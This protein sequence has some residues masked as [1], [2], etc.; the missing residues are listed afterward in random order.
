MTKIVN[1]PS[2]FAREALVGFCDIHAFAGLTGAD[3][4]DGALMGN[5]KV[6]SDFETC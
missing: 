3:V 6:L 2:D 5:I 4:A 1:D